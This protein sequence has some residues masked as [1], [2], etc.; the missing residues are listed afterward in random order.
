MVRHSN[1]WVFGLIPLD[2]INVTQGR[3][4]KKGKGSNAARRRTS[5]KNR[6]DT[7]FLANPITLK[8]YVEKFASRTTNFGDLECVQFKKMMREM[9]TSYSRLIQGFYVCIE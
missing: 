3:F 4:K 1:P 9:E 5:L 7:T 6:F 2:F 8:R